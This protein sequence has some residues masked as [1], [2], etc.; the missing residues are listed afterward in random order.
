[1]TYNVFSGTLNPTQ[2]ICGDSAIRYVLPV[3]WMTSCFHTVGRVARGVDSID[4]GGVLPLVR[5]NFNRI[6]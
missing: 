5:C 3:L 4:V 6:R 1:M 2:S